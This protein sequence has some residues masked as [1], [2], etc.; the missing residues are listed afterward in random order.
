MKFTTRIP[1]LLVV[2]LSSSLVAQALPPVS[3]SANALSIIF[4]DDLNFLGNSYSPARP[5]PDTC[6][7]LSSDWRNRAKSLIIGSGYS[8]SFH[9][10]TTC[11]GTGQALS[12]DV[13][14]L[15]STSS[16]PLYQNIESFE[17]T[18]QG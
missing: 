9:I 11:Q 12:G 17:C 6:I 8:C 14:E 18:K 3:R 16:P 5:I 7:T 10:F 15:S 13:G 2:A 4:F 1:A